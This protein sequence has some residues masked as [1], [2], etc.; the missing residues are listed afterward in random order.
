LIDVGANVGDTV[1]L[2]R[3]VSH[4]P[5]VC[6]EGDSYY[7]NILKKNLAQFEDVKAFNFFL[8]DENKKIPGKKESELGTLKIVTGEKNDLTNT[9]ELITL[10]NFFTM[11]PGFKSAKMLKIDT[12]GF[13]LRIL[14]GGKNYLADTKPVLFFEYDRILFEEAGEDGVN[15]LNILESIGYETAVFYDNYGRLILSAELKDKELI[16]QL[17]HYI[18][19]KKSAFPYY[20]I[21][22]FH[23]QDKELGRA[24]IKEEMQFFKS[25]DEEIL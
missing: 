24:F 1:A 17:H 16:S 4:F 14:R 8:G 2:S 20:D 6:I 11:N 21:A 19:G 5:I 22:L 23:L 18:Y 15:T 12:D 9:I 3:S 7:F 13:D 10:D 25:K